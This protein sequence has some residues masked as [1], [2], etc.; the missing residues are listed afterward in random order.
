MTK[1]QFKLSSEFIEL[2]K[3]LKLTGVAMSGGEAKN[4]INSGDV[5]INGEVTQVK[6]L[7]I[8]SGDKITVLDKEISVV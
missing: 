8:R 6:R 2:L 4:M 7:K 5:M 3:L 1:I